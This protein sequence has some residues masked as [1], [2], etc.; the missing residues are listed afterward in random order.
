MLH[1]PSM[2]PLPERTPV[3]EFDLVI[4]GASGDLAIRKLFPA[5]VRRMQAQWKL[6]RAYGIANLMVIH[7]LSDL[8]AIGDHGS[9][10]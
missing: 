1:S 7:R 3:P 8:D 4:A 2:L 9:G 5:L 6:S 10:R